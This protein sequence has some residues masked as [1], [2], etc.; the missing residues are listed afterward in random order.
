M[1]LATIAGALHEH[2]RG[3]IDWRSGLIAFGVNSMV[4][5]VEPEA[6]QLV[7][8]LHGHMAIVCL[9]RWAPQPPLH[10]AV[11]MRPG[12]ILASSDMT[13][14]II[15]W[16]SLQGV[17]LAVLSDILGTQPLKPVLSMHWLPS[18]MPPG[19]KPP[20]PPDV[21]RGEATL[22]PLQL[23]C[24]HETADLS[25]YQLEFVWQRSE[26]NKRRTS[27]VASVLW[28]QRLAISASARSSTSDTVIAVAV[29]SIDPGRIAIHYGKGVISEIANLGPTLMDLSA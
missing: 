26:A 25:A 14:Q 8:T 4:V 28:Q 6:V 23:F 9:V 1:G 2:N 22:Q 5:I 3:A 19:G 7:Q 27:T 12:S 13:G 11:T 15:I 16:D 24:V 20:P 21:D 17:A 18:Q 10:C 29:D